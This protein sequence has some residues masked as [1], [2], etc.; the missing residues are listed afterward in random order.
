MSKLGYCS[1]S[2]GFVLVRSGR[3]SV[4]GRGHRDP[5]YPVRA[6]DRVA[7]DGYSIVAAEK[8][9]LMMNKARGLVTTAADEEGRPTVYSLL[10]PALGWLAPVGRLDQSSEGLLLID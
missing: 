8:L 7:V 1:R 2:Q 10:D 6:T 4:N 5:E 3:V 9:Y